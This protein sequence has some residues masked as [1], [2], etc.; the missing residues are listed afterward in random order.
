MN[1]WMPLLGIAA[2]GVGLGILVLSLGHRRATKTHASPDR[3]VLKY[4][5]GAKALVIVVGTL[6]V[7]IALYLYSVG[8]ID[9]QA[10]LLIFSLDAL[11]VGYAGPEFFKTRIEFDAKRVYA[12]SAWRKPRTI[13]WSVIMACKYSPLKR[14]HAFDTFGFGALR[15]SDFMEGR[16]E[17]IAQ[18][19]KFGQEC[20]DFSQAQSAA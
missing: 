2:S 14:W 20:I 13:P 16:E 15:V 1:T 9:T 12:Y 11:F 19:K 6:L 4:G 18:F 8:R 5:D 7:A 17:F 10:A 3:H